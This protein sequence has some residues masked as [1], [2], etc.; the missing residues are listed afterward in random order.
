MKGLKRIRG[1]LGMG[2]TWAVGWSLA[3]VSIG[4]TSLL[5]PGLPWAAFFEVFD[6][7][8]PALA[9]PGFF[10]GLF[11]S[12]VLGI[13]GRGRRFHELSLARFAAW[14]VLGGLLLTAFPF[15]LVAVGMASREGSDIGTWQLLGAVTGPFVLLSA[16]SAVITLI[17]ARIAKRRGSRDD[18][19]LLGSGIHPL[20]YGTARPPAEGARPGPAN[21][22]SDA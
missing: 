19:E 11:F 12:T 21:D 3:G 18:L 7:P 6:A 8:L 22:R 1:A 2:V 14:G 20:A 10:A 17:L 4:V 9:V 13:A 5:L 16:L 15:A